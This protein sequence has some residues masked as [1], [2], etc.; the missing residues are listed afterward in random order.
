MARFSISPLVGQGD[1][2][3]R[4]STVIA[5]LARVDAPPQVGPCESRRASMRRRLSV[6]Q[7][8][9]IAPRQTASEALKSTLPLSSSAEHC[10]VP[11]CRGG[12]GKTDHHQGRTSA[13]TSKCQRDGCRSAAATS[14]ESCRIDPDAARRRLQAWVARSITQVVSHSL[15]S[16]AFVTRKGYKLALPLVPRIRSGRCASQ[17][18]A[19]LPAPPSLAA[20]KAW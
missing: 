4:G 9:R 15:K 6:R 19:S 3:N 2:A 16:L 14:S 20:S 7:A 5:R 13:G 18:F 8:G 1:G 11:R 10:R 17:F 12:G